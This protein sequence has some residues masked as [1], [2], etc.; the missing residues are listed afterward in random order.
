[1]GVTFL[2]APRQA[3]SFTD[4]ERKE[5]Q[6]PVPEVIGTRVEGEWLIPNGKYLL[7]SLGVYTVADGEGKAVVRDRLIMIETEPVVRDPDG[8]QA[9]GRA[10]KAK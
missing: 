4:S 9:E 8:A 7:V 3:G 2:I 6:V 5:T 1:M 10:T